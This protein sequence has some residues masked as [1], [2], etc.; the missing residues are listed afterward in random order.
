MKKNLTLLGAL[1]NISVFAQQIN[2][3]ARGIV[4]IS[5]ADMAASACMD[6]RLLKE[7]GARDQCSVIKFPFQINDEIKSVLASNS[8][9]NWTKGLAI[10]PN[11]KFAYVVE[12]RGA[13]ADNITEV[14]DINADLPAGGFVTVIDIADLNQPKVLFKFPTGKNPLAVEVSPS[15]E[16]LAITTEDYGKE[17]QVL[18]LD[19]TGKPIRIINKPQSFPAG[20]VSD[21]SWH[22]NSDFLAFT[23]EDSKEV[24]LIKVL[25][26]GPTQKIIRTELVGK[27]VKVGSFPAGGQFT[28]DGKYYLV[29]DMK[30]L[31]ATKS[32][33]SGDSKGEIFVM[34]FNLEGTTD[35][36]LLTK[37][38]VGENPENFAISPDGSLIAV[39]NMNHSFYPWDSP[40]LTKKSSISLLKL[41]EDGTLNNLSE[42]EFEG[43][44]PQG[45]TFDT[46]GENLAV[47]VYDYFNFG[48]RLGGIEFWK[49]NRGEKPSLT[50]QDIKFYLNRGVHSVK[51][52][53]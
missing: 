49:V 20:K 18:E 21:I 25:R 11:G 15:G 4:A 36:Y 9:T 2:F 5:D 45:I 41:S 13:V 50:K 27:P 34:R 33:A 17:L 10:S 1:I 3:N 23:L 16:Y 37:A 19:A 7:K 29:A 43:I 31:N 48:K 32:E 24:G 51:I 28:P 46:K 26:D 35:H 6:G 52:L 22:P 47:T 14:K 40:Q 44:M 38:K 8:A 12:S 53:K 39:A 42:Y 30:W